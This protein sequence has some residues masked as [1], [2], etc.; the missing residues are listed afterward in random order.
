MDRMEMR[1]QFF[2]SKTSKKKKKKLKNKYVCKLN[3][4]LDLNVTCPI[5]HFNSNG[6]SILNHIDILY[7]VPH[8]LTLWSYM[9]N[10][11]CV[12]HNSIEMFKVMTLFNIHFSPKSFFSHVIRVRVCGG[13]S[14]CAYLWSEWLLMTIFFQFLHINC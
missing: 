8:I 10:N 11:W 7:A 1:E 4:L 2:V 12:E 14:E 9:K 3:A 5:Y 13:V 6:V